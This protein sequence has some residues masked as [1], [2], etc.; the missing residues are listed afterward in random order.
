MMLAYFLDLNAGD[1]IASHPF[2]LLTQK[3]ESIELFLI[4]GIVDGHDIWR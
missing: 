1:W 3:R 2:D 4:K